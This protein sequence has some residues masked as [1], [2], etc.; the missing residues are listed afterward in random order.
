[1]NGNYLADTNFL[2]D[3]FEEDPKSIQFL[4]TDSEIFLC[5][6]VL[7]ELYYGAFNSQKAISNIQK[8][9]QFSSRF[10]ILNCDNETSK[11]YGH[12]KS[13]LKSKGTPIPENDIWIAAIA[14]QHNLTL[15]TLDKHFVNV[16][17]I[18]SKSWKASF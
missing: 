8:I 2:I 17:S 3:L 18:K 15:L 4:Q 9:D 16:E 6:T 10:D 5:A 7:G 1:M 14:Y 13:N 11:V 12:I